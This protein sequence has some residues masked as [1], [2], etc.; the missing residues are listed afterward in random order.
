MTHISY[1]L[2]NPS[3]ESDQPVRDAFLLGHDV[4]GRRQ[5][6]AGQ[7]VSAACPAIGSHRKFS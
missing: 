7:R 4:H 6:M 5:R 2:F 3:D 1:M